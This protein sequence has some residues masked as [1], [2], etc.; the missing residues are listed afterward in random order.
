MIVVAS[1]VL[2]GLPTRLGGV[3]FASIILLVSLVLFY[4]LR[5]TIN[6]ESLRAS[7]GIGIIC[8]RVPLAE[9]IG[10]EPIRLSDGTAG[11]FT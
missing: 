1:G 5:I 6:A 8:K 7:F 10:C 3:L 9:I 2:V 4:K 11:E